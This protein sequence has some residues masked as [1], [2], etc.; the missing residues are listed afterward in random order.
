MVAAFAAYQASTW[1]EI[2]AFDACRGSDRSAMAHRQSPGRTV[3]VAV[4]RCWRSG[5]SR[6]GRSG[7]GRPSRRIAHDGR[8]SWG[9]RFSATDEAAVA[10]NTIPTPQSV[11]TSRLPHAGQQVT[12]I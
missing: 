4:F 3:T 5:P 11:S 1:R 7:S 10:G 6:V 12:D 9:S 8:Q 2:A